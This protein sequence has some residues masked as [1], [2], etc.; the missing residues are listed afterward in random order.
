MDRWFFGLEGWRDGNDTHDLDG[1][2]ALDIFKSGINHVTLL[3]KLQFLW[4]VK[5]WLKSDPDSPILL[6]SETQTT[7]NDGFFHF[8]DPVK[9]MPCS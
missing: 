3:L 8:S 5:F 6:H 9:P 1:F 2:E 4:Q 7:R